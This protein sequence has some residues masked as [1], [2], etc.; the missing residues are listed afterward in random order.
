[1]DPTMHGVTCLEYFP[2]SLKYKMV[3]LSN[4]DAWKTGRKKEKK[5]KRQGTTPFC[6]LEGLQLMLQKNWLN[7]Q[8]LQ[9]FSFLTD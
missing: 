7:I 9:G 3:L 1:M 8:L 2:V 6:K 4:R 5:K